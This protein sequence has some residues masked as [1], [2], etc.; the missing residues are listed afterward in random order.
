MN[1]WA[2]N[3]DNAIRQLL[4]VLSDRFGPDA[5]AISRRWEKE[6]NAVGLYQPGEESLLAYLFTYGQETGRYGLH[7]EY[8]GVNGLSASTEMIEDIGLNH[9]IDLLQ[10]HFDIELRQCG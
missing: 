7:L 4:H 1:V 10:A 2:L 3:K 6:V 9:L 5:L 8:P